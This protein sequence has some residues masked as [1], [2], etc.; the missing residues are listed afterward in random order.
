M[1]E[2]VCD[3]FPAEEHARVAIAPVSRYLNNPDKVAARTES[4]PSLLKL[5]FFKP[6]YSF[7]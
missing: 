7:T 5:G 3:D 4:V 1:S 6:I 2:I